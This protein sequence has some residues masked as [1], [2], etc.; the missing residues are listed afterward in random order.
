[1]GDGIISAKG[2]SGSA[3]EGGG[4][5]GG[6]FVMKFLKGY[7][8]E[9]YPVSSWW[10]GSTIMDGGHSG[11]K[12]DMFGDPGHGEEG[13]I[14]SSKCLPGYSGVFCKA[15]PLGTF[16]AEYSFG[17][18]IP[19]ENKPTN[20]FY[21]RQAEDSSICEYECNESGFFERAIHNP[22]CLDSI[23]LEFQRLGGAFPFFIVLMTFLWISML[24]F[25]TI[26]S[27]SL[28]IK[29]MQ[30]VNPEIHFRSWSHEEFQ[31]PK[32][33]ESDFGLKD[34]EIWYH[35]H[36]MYLT[37]NNTPSNPWK[38]TKEFPADSLDTIELKKFIGFIDGFNK[39]LEY[40]WIEMFI[41][42]L[43]RVFLR[44]FIRDIECIFRKEK[45]TRMQ[46]ALFRHFPPQFWSNRGDNKTIRLDCCKDD[47][48]L[49]YFD[50]VDF[51]KSQEN[52]QGF[53]LP[54]EVMC[55]GVGTFN[56]PFRVNY[57]DDPYL[58]QIVFLKFDFLKDKLPVFLD[59][60]NTQISKLS[61]FKLHVQILRDL[62]KT[63]RWMENANKTMFNH[64]GVKCTLFVVEN[65]M[66]EIE[67]G[68]MGQRN[69]SF[70]LES[71]FFEVFPEMYD[72]LVRYLRQKTI[73]KKSLIRIVIKFTKY[74]KNKA[75]ATKLRFKTMDAIENASLYRSA[76]LRGESI[77][78]DVT[79]TEESES[80]VSFSNKVSDENQYL[81]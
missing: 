13:T 74:D 30:K 26:N 35:T 81:P 70:P 67:E 3:N 5:S 59:N 71:T 60:F 27:N 24:I 68:V 11:Q 28:K 15:C 63:V 40:D 50:F 31:T 32:H 78:F 48:K 25:V 4:G 52:W 79:D 56:H 45:F 10:S 39:R 23:S 14:M 41:I 54:M 51:S 77:L 47:Y 7:L 57:Q 2:G 34:Q 76:V 20:S 53:K 9:S 80:R 58:K 72:R 61:F 69:R 21:I 37:G 29:E 12:F 18:C 46:T 75:I 49:A 64:F 36:R 62:S 55:A 17:E 22:D 73:E 16:K 66:K 38:I 6:R 43:T 1:M 19:C 8:Q 44:P 42:N 33:S 65:Q